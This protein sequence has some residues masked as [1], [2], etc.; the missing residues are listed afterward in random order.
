MKILYL[1]GYE[2]LLSQNQLLRNDFFG[3]RRYEA[4]T[5]HIKPFLKNIKGKERQ[6]L[7]C[8]ISINFYQL[9]I[10]KLLFIP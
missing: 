4:L 5:Q 7:H 10:E 3:Y 2:W 6:F 1:K 8:N 9:Q